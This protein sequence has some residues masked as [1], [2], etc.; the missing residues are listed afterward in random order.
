MSRYI[1][2]IILCMPVFTDAADGPVFT[3]SKE[4]TFVTKPINEEGFVDFTTAVNMKLSKGITS[5][6]N[7][8]SVIFPAFGPAP[9]G[10]PFSQRFF[11]ELGVSIPPE[12]GDYYKTLEEFLLSQGVKKNS[13][14]M[15]RIVENRNIAMSRPWKREEF[16]KIAGWLVS[17][18]KPLVSITKGTQQES[19]YNP[20]NSPAL[21]GAIKHELMTTSLQHLQVSRSVARSLV[22]RAMQHIAE[23]RTKSAWGDLLAAYRL[24]LHLGNGSSLIEA[25]VGVSIEAYTNEAVIKFIEETQ[26][27]R[28]LA[29]QYL[30]NIEMLPK[31]ALV[32]AQVDFG[33][34]LIVIDMIFQTMLE[35]YEESPKLKVDWD[36]VLR[37]SNQWFDRIVVGL[38][39]ESFSAREKAWEQIRS[40]LLRVSKERTKSTG[41]SKKLLFLSN[42]IKRT[43]EYFSDLIIS[44]F[45]PDARRASV[46]VNRSEQRFDNLRVALS[47]SAYH[48][49]HKTYPDQLKE[50]VPRY[51]PSLPQD[52]FGE[53]PLTYMKTIDGYL[54]YS[55]GQNQTDDGGDSFDVGKDDLTVRISSH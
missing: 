1:A 52:L 25:L 39:Q 9:G 40:D 20:I 14:E 32:V 13:L 43:T 21:E 3:V 50:L 28:E 54:L 38:K 55:V 45:I 12:K 49:T 4:T 26:P 48:S 29:F 51:L 46:S 6:N 10:I 16:P 47:L 15:Q 33:A 19:Y 22:S 2:L 8:A 42:D 17:N 23:N 36:Q 44:S 35:T 53:K 24:G 34:R 27:N 31:R 11:E 41:F 7:A 30:N 18:A 37:E 5:K